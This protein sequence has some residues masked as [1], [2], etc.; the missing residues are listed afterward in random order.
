MAQGPP[1]RMKA[2]RVLPL[3]AVLN[4]SGLQIPQLPQFVPSHPHITQRV[5]RLILSSD[6]VEANMYL[7]PSES[8]LVAWIL[9]FNFGQFRPRYLPTLHVPLLSMDLVLPQRS[10]SDTSTNATSREC[11]Y[12]LRFEP[13]RHVRQLPLSLPTEPFR[14]HIVGSELPLFSQDDSSTNLKLSRRPSL[15]QSYR[16]PQ[17]PQSATRRAITLRVA[18]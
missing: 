16:Y 15:P 3:P 11:A 6:W 1:S 13:V 17:M 2:K 5:Q 9:P 18:G 7:E 14:I 12:G 4:N 10:S 8:H